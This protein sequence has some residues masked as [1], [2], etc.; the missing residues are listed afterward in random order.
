MNYSKEQFH[1]GKEYIKQKNYEKA[2]ECF[3]NSIE[4]DRNY[5]EAFCGR[6]IAYANQGKYEEAIKDYNKAIE[7]DREYKEAFNNRGIAHKYKE[8]YEK[9]IEDFTK[10]IELDKDYKEAFF[11]RGIAYIYQNE[12]KKAI[13]D[14]TKVI[15]IE[16]NCKEAFLARAMIYKYKEEYEKAIEDCVKAIEIDKGYGKVYDVRSKIYSELKEHTKIVE[17]K[18]EYSKLEEKDK[19]EYFKL[20]EYKEFFDYL[21][22]KTKNVEKEIAENLERL[23]GFIF[24]FKENMKYEHTGDDKANQLGHYT[25]IQNM[26]F[27]IKKDS[28]SDEENKTY[29]RLNN[30]EYMNDPDEGNTFFELFSKDIKCK[31]FLKEIYGR[32]GKESEE[33]VEI[34][35]EGNIFLV[36]L[37]KNIDN[38]LPMWRQYANDGD[39]CCLV[40]DS[41]FFKEENDEIKDNEIKDNLNL[42]S[43]KPYFDGLYK[44]NYLGNRKKEDNTDI[45]GSEYIE[46]ISN[47]LLKIEKMLAGEEENINKIVKELISEI[48]D[49]IRFLF[50]D[51]AYSYEEEIR[52]IKFKNIENDKDVQVTGNAEGFVVPHLYVN[53]KKDIVLNEVVLGPKVEN[54]KGIANYIRYTGKVEKVT[55]SKIRYK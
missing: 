55:K 2:L 10:V 29:L 50:K 14:F 43:F 18:E 15:E 36:S 42:N 39:G 8:E 28:K 52:L 47:V 34:K 17:E 35:G 51:S 27:L 4:M 40:F 19:I 32:C 21:G 5:K 22:D 31:N 23:A 49:N 45:D 11:Y 6:G 48:I 37:S 30:I 13:E 16:E 54:E 3:T 25:K 53:F 7:I 46:K 20:K 38:S 1:K 24:L 44:V 26:K 33:R 12:F 41:E 9:A